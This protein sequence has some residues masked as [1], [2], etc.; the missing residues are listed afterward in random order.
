MW[1]GPARQQ[2]R[3]HAPTQLRLCLPPLA[4]NP[5]RLLHEPIKIARLARLAQAAGFVVPLEL[6]VGVLLGQGLGDRARVGQ[7]I[8]RREP[9]DTIATQYLQE[10]YVFVNA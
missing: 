7:R 9:L 3:V 10:S 1:K 4:G 6:A 8:V 5:L 2:A